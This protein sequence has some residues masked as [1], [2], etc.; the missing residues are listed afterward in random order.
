MKR[1]L[2]ALAAR[3]PILALVGLGFGLWTASNQLLAP[4]R[5]VAEFLTS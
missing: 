3:I 2:L 5:R 4:S 1:I